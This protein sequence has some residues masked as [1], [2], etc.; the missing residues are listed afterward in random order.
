MGRL[1]V[2]SHVFIA[3]CAVGIIVSS[4]ASAALPVLLFLPGE[5]VPVEL[6]GA[7]TTKWEL[8]EKLGELIAGQ[9]VQFAL[10]F[11]TAGS[12]LG[13]FESWLLAAEE[14]IGKEKCKTTGDAAGNVLLG[15]EVHLVFDSLTPLGVAAL[16]LIVENTP[17]DCGV[18]EIK[19][20]GNL[21]GLITPINTEVL[22][23][24]RFKLIIRCKAMNGQPSEKTYWN[25]AGEART[26]KLE[27]SAGLGF[28]EG[29]VNVN[30]EV[31]LA[32]TKM[33][34]IMG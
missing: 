23:S 18:L 8:Q 5:G 29:C 12:N 3:A 26:A 28:E 25:A 14:P 32:P 1:K 20:R 16:F 6:K 34:E 22:T 15:N 4:S 9:G 10:K 2:L 19:L 33:L 13:P 27:V 7:S 17:I 30:E 24:G 11:N 21:L 31:A